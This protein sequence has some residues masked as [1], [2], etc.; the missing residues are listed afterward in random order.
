LSSASAT[1]ALLKSPGGKIP[2]SSLKN[3]VLHPSSDIVTT[4]DINTLSSCLSAD[5]RLKV[6]VHHQ[7]VTI[8][9]IFKYYS[10]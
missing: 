3:Q 7:I 2:Y 10:K 8:F 5:T 6:Q 9:F 1:I 4:V